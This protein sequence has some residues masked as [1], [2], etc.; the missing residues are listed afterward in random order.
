MFDR[1]FF[2]VIA[3]DQ[4]VYANFRK[5]SRPFIGAFYGDFTNGVIKLFATLFQNVNHL[6][7]SAAPTP[8]KVLL[9]GEDQDSGGPPMTKLRAPAHFLPRTCPVRPT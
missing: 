9:W 8:P 7:G 3:P 2:Q 1:A 5:D 4:K 6:T